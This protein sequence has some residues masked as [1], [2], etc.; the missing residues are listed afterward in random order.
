MTEETSE[1][2]GSPSDDAYPI[3]PPEL[4]PAPVQPA[5]L[6][7]QPWW[8][9]AGAVVIGLAVVVTVGLGMVTLFGSFGNAN[10]AQ[11]QVGYLAA[12][13]QISQDIDGLMRVI[14]SESVVVVPPGRWAALKAS[15]RP[16]RTSWGRPTWKDGAVI[17]PFTY[18]G[19]TRT[20]TAEP[21]GQDPNVV[22]LTVTVPKGGVIVGSVRLTREG[23]GWKAIMIRLGDREA[24]YAPS[25]LSRTI[26]Q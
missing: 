14:P 21:Q 9:I 16:P 19:T 3:V 17:V 4:V 25:D 20:L 24:S 2:T 23:S 10:R 22:T 8:R 7:R 6:P 15:L 11:V 1:K 5:R 26:G 12:R 18:D 13:A